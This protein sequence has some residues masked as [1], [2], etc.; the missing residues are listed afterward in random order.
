MVL[1]S[2]YTLCTHAHNVFRF[3]TLSFSHSVSFER[4]IPLAIQQRHT[5]RK[6]HTRTAQPP[7][8]RRLTYAQNEK[9]EAKTSTKLHRFMH[10]AAITTP[11]TLQAKETFFPLFWI[12]FWFSAGAVVVAHIMNI[13][14]HFHAKHSP[15]LDGSC[16]SNRM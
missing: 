15:L 2:V 11:L 13:S 12:F 4:T 1:C 6:K 10:A 9:K 14:F 5:Q 3:F 16:V 8:R 7:T